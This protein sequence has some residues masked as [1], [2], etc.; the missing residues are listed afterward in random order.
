MRNHK[1]NIEGYMRVLFNLEEAY[2]TVNREGIWQVYDVDGKLLSRIK[3]LYGNSLACVR[4]KGGEMAFCGELEEDLKVMVGHFVGV[5]KRSGLKVNADKSKVMVL[6][7]EEGWGVSL[8]WMGRDWRKCQSS[9][10]WDVF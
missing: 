1:R 4:V 10:I 6:G 5:C 7:R 2:D 9:N 3:S 8:M